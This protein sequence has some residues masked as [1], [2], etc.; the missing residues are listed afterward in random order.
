MLRNIQQRLGQDLPIGNHDK[1]IWLKILNLLLKRRVLDAVWLM[2][3][4]PMR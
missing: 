1:K 4:N 3:R 2:G